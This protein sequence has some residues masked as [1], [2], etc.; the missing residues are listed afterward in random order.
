M[1]LDATE[2]RGA[3]LSGDEPRMELDAMPRRI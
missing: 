2:R 1:E 3:E